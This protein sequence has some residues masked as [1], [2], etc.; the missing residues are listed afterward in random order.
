MAYLFKENMCYNIIFSGERNLSLLDLP[1]EILTKILVENV[2]QYEILNSLRFVCTRF[3]VVIG[4]GLKSVTLAESQICEELLT[5]LFV[6]SN[7][8]Y[9]T[10]ACQT[11][12]VRCSA[13]FNKRAIHDGPI[14]LA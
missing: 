7:L 14:S 11:G 4:C 5:F 2:S 6:F 12:N 13:V 3:A 1:D 8:E 10:V 9:L